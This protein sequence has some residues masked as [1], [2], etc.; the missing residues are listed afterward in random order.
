MTCV[1]THSLAGD[2]DL[3]TTAHGLLGTTS[4]LANAFGN[5]DVPPPCSL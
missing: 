2:P 3:A 1:T 4:I 5:R